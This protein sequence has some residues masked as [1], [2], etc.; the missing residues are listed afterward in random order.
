M[1]SV[2]YILYGARI[3]GRIAYVGIT[4][5]FNRRIMDHSTSPK[6]LA[7][8]HAVTWEILAIIEGRSN[9]MREENKRIFL[10]KQRGNCSLNKTIKI[11][12]EKVA[13]KPAEAVENLET[14]ARQFE[15][16]CC[17]RYWRGFPLMTVRK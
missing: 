10:E 9:A 7:I 6:F 3:K 14:N 15:S 4:N 1:T 11:P 8:F 12:I 17:D 16:P 13:A 2:P 5:N